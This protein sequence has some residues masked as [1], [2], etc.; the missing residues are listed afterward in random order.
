MENNPDPELEELIHRELRGVLARSAPATL[1]PRV[2]AALE[3]R[4]RHWWL[5]PWLSWPRGAQ[6]I[7]SAVLLAILAAIAYLSLP[8]SDGLE[9]KPAAEMIWQRFPLAEML[10]GLGASL[11]NGLLVVLRA[12]QPWVAY[13][14]GAVFLMYLMCIGIGTACFRVALNERSNAGT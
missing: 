10:W 1:I 2:L 7:S 5:R 9:T 12:G 6:V 8:G 14:L 3:E 4:A 11:W 13:G